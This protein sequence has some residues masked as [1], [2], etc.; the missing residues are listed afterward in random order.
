MIS[1]VV[2]IEEKLIVI[3]VEGVHKGYSMFVVIETITL[4]VI[5]KFIH[6]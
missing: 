6:R 1:D 5:C 4:S 3:R 2:R